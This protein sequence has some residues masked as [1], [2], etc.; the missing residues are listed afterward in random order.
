MN[1]IFIFDVDG[2]LTPSRQ[3]MTEEFSKFFD[4]WSSKNTYYL[5]T[6]SD[7]EK[8]QEQVPIAYLDR[9]AGIFTCG[10]NNFYIDNKL[11]Y[12]HKFNPPKKL[13]KY[14]EKQL[15]ESTYFARCGNHIENRGSML[16]FSIVGRDCNLEE[17]KTYFE[18]DKYTKERQKITTEINILWPKLNATIGGQI[19]IDI[20]P[21]G[22]DKSQVIY[23]VGKKSPGFK[24]IFIGD[25]TMKGGNDYPLARIMKKRTDDC[26]VHQAGE[27]SA[28]DGYRKTWW[29]L[30]RYELGLEK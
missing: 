28:E 23:H 12:E 15:K 21:K 9:S 25:R 22:Y 10:G 4:K 2:T 11:Q 17:R 16:N 8:I 20:A 19:S 3:R 26:K 29:Y 1:K 6:G 27:P 7:L 13:I 30:Q 18:Y 5:V 24:Y 14:L